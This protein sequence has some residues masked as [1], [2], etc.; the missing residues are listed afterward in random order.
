M[1]VK[2][3]CIMVLMVLAASL[4]AAKERYDVATVENHARVRDFVYKSCEMLRLDEKE[5][6]DNELLPQEQ[7]DQ[8]LDSVPKG[9]VI[10]TNL[11]G[12]IWEMANGTNW[13]YVIKDESGKELFRTRGHNYREPPPA[14]EMYGYKE[15]T[16]FGVRSYSRE[17]MVAPEKTAFGVPVY[18]ALDRIEI[19][20]PL[21]DK[22][23]VYIA[24]GI[25]RKRCS[26]FLKKVAN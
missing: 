22:F 10:Y 6:A 4:G 9:G 1:K 17:V 13:T 2:A 21:P 19:P 16:R 23:T 11:L 7:I 20:I 25:N 8:L 14:Y 5:R 26:Y 3:F 12:D 15:R 24:D 18:V